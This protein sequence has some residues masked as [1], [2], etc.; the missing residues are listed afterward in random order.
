LGWLK[1][2]PYIELWFIKTKCEIPRCCFVACRL[3]H[4]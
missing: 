2:H 1:Q 4:K 3:Q